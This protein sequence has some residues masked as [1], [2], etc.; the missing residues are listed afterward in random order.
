MERYQLRKV[1]VAINENQSNVSY[2]SDSRLSYL[3]YSLIFIQEFEFLWGAALESFGCWSAQHLYCS[4]S[5]YIKWY[6]WLRGRM[7]D[8][9]KKMYMTG[10]GGRWWRTEPDNISFATG[11]GSL[12]VSLSSE[13]R[14]WWQIIEAFSDLS[15]IERAI[16]DFEMRL[17]AGEFRDCIKYMGFRNVWA[18]SLSLRMLCVDCQINRLESVLALAVWQRVVGVGSSGQI[19]R[20]R[21]DERRYAK[22]LEREWVCTGGSHCWC[23]L[24]RNCLDW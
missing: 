21:I 10:C 24:E 18:G 5:E 3:K 8:L 23:L 15:F 6:W 13:D 2:S 19:K 11:I 12:P 17:Q 14:Y 7:E 1:Q 16:Q 9:R 4:A 20:D 22:L